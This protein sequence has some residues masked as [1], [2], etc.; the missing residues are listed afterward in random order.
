MAK[1]T[2]HASGASIITRKRVRLSISAVTVITSAT[3][4]ATSIG[5]AG[6]I[7]SGAPGKSLAGPLKETTSLAMIRLTN[8][9]LRLNTTVRRVL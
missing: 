7:R 4:W 1:H 9:S 6:Q 2:T 8:R 5:I 3:A